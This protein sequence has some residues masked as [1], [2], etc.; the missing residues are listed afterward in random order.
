MFLF[1]LG[2]GGGILTILG[3]CIQTFDAQDSLYANLGKPRIHPAEGVRKPI[4]A[5]ARRGRCSIVMRSR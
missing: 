2:Y 4:S 3:P 5:T 1:F